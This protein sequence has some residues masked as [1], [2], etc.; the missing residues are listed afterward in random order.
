VIRNCSFRFAPCQKT[1]K[2]R[3]TLLTAAQRTAF[4]EDAAQL[5]IPHAT[6]VQLQT[7]GVNDAD[8]L[9]DFNKDA[10][11]QIAADPGRPA[12]RTPDPN[13]AAAAGVK[14]PMPPFVF[15]AKSQQRLSH[16]AKLVRCCDA[17]GRNATAGNPQWTPFMKNF[18]EQ[19]KA[20]KD[21]KGGDEPEVP[22][23]TK[24]LPIV[25]WTKASR[26]HLHR[27]ISVC[28]I[29]LAHHVIGPEASAPPT[30]TQAPGTPHS[31]EH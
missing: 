6:V 22:K 7:E 20:L 18:S 15:G 31:T 13:P 26:D 3:R 10:I 24:A 11:E 16:A 1:D 27:A 29:P 2:G 19:W 8:D 25:K 30:G 4:F 14:I 9:V 12:G 23:I 28:T 17:V 5:G 21:K